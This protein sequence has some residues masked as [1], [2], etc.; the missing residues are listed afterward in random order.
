MYINSK[1]RLENNMFIVLILQNNNLY[2]ELDYDEEM[3]IGEPYDEFNVYKHNPS[4]TLIINRIYYDKIPHNSIEKNNKL[5]D[6][7]YLFMFNRTKL[8]VEFVHNKISY[9]L[10]DTGVEYADDLR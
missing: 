7:N 6:G 2:Y 8:Y 4:G 10:E 5:T 1:I 3:Y 9:K